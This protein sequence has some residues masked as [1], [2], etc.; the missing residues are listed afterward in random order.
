MA[1]ELKHVWWGTILGSDNKPLKTKSGETIKLQAL[2]DEA[3]DRA[4]KVVSEKNP[5]LSSDEKKNI[6]CSWHRRLKIRRSL[7]TEPKITFSI[8][9]GCSVL[10]E[11]P[12]HIYST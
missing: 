9:T 12:L 2:I 7:L 8:G 1:P 5:N 10:K 4:H 6:A 11:I 3:V